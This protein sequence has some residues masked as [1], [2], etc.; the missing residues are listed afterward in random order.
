MIKVM[1]II[2]AL[3]IQ[4][5]S[6]FANKIKCHKTNTHHIRNP[7]SFRVKVFESR[8]FFTDGNDKDDDD[9]DGDDGQ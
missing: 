5:R 4:G 6:K 2:Q 9:D 1:T 8:S 3:P 7:Y